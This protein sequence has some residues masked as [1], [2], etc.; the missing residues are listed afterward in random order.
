MDLCWEHKIYP[1]VKVVSTTD[2]NKCWED[3]CSE[4]NPN[5]DGIRFVIDMKKSK[6]D[7]KDEIEKLIPGYQFTE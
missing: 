1:D 5:P 6:L 7:N 4:E 3:L 2:I